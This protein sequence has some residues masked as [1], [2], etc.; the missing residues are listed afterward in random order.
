M[1]EEFWEN[2]HVTGV[3]SEYSRF[4]NVVLI[5]TYLDLYAFTKNVNELGAMGIHEAC[6]KIISVDNK[7]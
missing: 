1:D 7:T 5:L 3:M 2:G 4:L 6:Y